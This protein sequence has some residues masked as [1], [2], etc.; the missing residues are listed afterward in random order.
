M[1][2]VML[3]MTVILAVFISKPVKSECNLP[4]GISDTPAWTEIG[5][6]PIYVDSDCTVNVYM[7]Y[8]EVDGECQVVLN[9]LHFKDSRDWFERNLWGEDH[10]SKKYKKKMQMILDK[11]V[12]EVAINYTFCTPAPL[13]DCD[14]SP[15][16][17]GT[18]VF[19]SSCETD[20]I[21]DFTKHNGDYV[22]RACT[23][24][25]YCEYEYEWCKKSVNGVLK[26]VYNKTLINSNNQC[27]ETYELGGV[28]Y[29]CF[30][31]DCHESRIGIKVPSDNDFVNFDDDTYYIANDLSTY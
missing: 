7:C 12:S 16:P 28:S 19:A 9:Y 14:T 15:L 24:D 18:R 4:D 27:A 11:A 10:C 30:P 6:I 17:T 8:R 13:P 22:V 21:P 3:I 25:S 20:L 5:P 2:K 31:G 1:K 23:G 26:A 29:Y